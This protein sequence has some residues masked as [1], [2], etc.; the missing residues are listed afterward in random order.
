MTPRLSAKSSCHLPN[1][2]MRNPKWSE[3]PNIARCWRSS[4]MR[5]SHLHTKLVWHQWYRKVS[6]WGGLWLAIDWHAKGSPV[7]LNLRVISPTNEWTG[8]PQQFITIV[9]RV[10]QRW[11]ILSWAVVQGVKCICGIN[12]KDSFSW[13]IIEAWSDSMDTS[14][15]TSYLSSTQ[16]EGPVASSISRWRRVMDRTDLAIMHLMVSQIV[17]ALWV[18]LC[19]HIHHIVMVW[20]P[21]KYKCLICLCKCSA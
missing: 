3:C 12:L 2:H 10:G 15:H 6:W 19:L 16:L 13:L 7:W 9:V 18:H 21:P 14:L 20:A 5:Q 4:L 8:S 11:R 17:S 1:S